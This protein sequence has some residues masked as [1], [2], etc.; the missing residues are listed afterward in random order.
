MTDTLGVVIPAYRPDIDALTQYVRGIDTQLS[1]AVLRVEI[2]SPQPDQLSALDAV[3]AELDTTPVEIN[4]VDRRRGKGGAI[5]E[6]FDSLG[7][8][9]LAFADADGSVP[10]ASLVDV[11]APTRRSETALSVGSRRHPDAEIVDHQT[12]GRRLLGDAFAAVARQLLPTRCYDYQCG[13]KALRAEAWSDIRHYC[14]ERGFA[15]DL[16]LLSV[17]DRLGYEVSEVPV[18][19]EDHPDTT[20]DPIPTAIELGRAL[21]VIRSRTGGLRPRD[22][23]QSADRAATLTNDGN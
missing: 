10:A 18:T 9:I 17:A 6:G 23:V 15:W 21:L 12:V 4:A 22:R 14:Y 1:P 19:W 13:A 5:T 7:T 8:D 11:V 3:A 16:E 20:V 2:D